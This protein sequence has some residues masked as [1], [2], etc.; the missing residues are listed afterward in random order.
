MPDFDRETLP[1][2]DRADFDHRLQ[3]ALADRQIDPRD[4]ERLTSFREE[5]FLYLP[6]LIDEDLVDAV[7]ADYER[8]WRERPSYLRALCEGLGF[9]PLDRTPDRSEM[10]HHHYRL[11]DLQDFSEAIRGLMLHAA[12]V[13]L[14]G[15]ILGATPVA[16]QSIFFEYGSEQRLHQDFPILRPIIPSHLVGCWVALEDVR[17]DC[18]PLFYFPGSHR[19]PKHDFGGNALGISRHEDDLGGYEEHLGAVVRAAGIESRVLEAGKGDVFLWHSA[20]VHGGSPVE[21]HE[22]T[23]QSMVVHYST[24]AACPRDRRVPDEAPRW[25]ERNRGLLFDRLD[26]EQG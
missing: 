5:G 26:V 22:P 10:P 8:A 13:E 15:R 2:V 12:L 9:V 20:L 3:R 17:P 7:V 4:G 6:G 11:L 25:V 24:V 16:M 1:W 18:G 19:L 21:N 23:R 14:V